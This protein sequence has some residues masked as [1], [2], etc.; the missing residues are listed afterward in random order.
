ML[1][2]DCDCLPTRGEDQQVGALLE[3]PADQ[4]C[5]SRY[6]V[7]TIVHQQ[8]ALP[9]AEEIDE[10]ING[11]LGSDHGEPDSVHRGSDD[12]SSIDDRGQV[13]KERTA[14]KGRMGP[15]CRLDG[16]AGLPGASDSDN[17]HQSR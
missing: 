7:L 8:Q 1:A 16:E 5:C 14:G 11:G 10:A 12:V 2:G 13:D 15:V 6:H 9:R 3:Q 17:S 4:V